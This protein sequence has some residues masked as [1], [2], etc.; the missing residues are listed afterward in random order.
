MPLSS[1]LLVHRDARLSADDVETLCA[2]A[3][4]ARRALGDARS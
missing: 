2:W 4:G 1:Y 3:E